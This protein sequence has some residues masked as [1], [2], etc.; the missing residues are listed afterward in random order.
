M[1]AE[2]EYGGGED[3]GGGEGWLEDRADGEKWWKSGVSR[4]KKAQ[5][6]EANRAS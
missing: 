4:M 1:V 2:G 5:T 6:S 3:R